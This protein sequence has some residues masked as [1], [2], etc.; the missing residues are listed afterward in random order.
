MPEAVR[1]EKIVAGGVGL[2]RLSDGRVVFVPR[3]APSDLAQVEVIEEHRT[4]TRGR[5]LDVRGPGPER[6]DPPC[7]YYEVCGSCQLQHLSYAAQL[8]AKAG[9]ITDALRRLGGVA[10][11]EPEVIGS[12]RQLEYRNRVT[13]V[14]LREDVV[15]AG[16]HTLHD[17]EAILDVER[18][19]LAEPAINAAWAALRGA[20][21]TDAERLPGGAELRLTLRATAGGKVG[22][23][24]E[25]GEGYGDVE[26]LLESIPDLESIWGL[27]VHGEPEWYAGRRALKDTW[28]GHEL[29]LAGLSF[30]QVN[31]EA[32]GL[33]EE[34]VRAQCGQVA[35]RRI[36]D[37]YCG[38][39][40][41]ALDLA[42]EGA[43]VVGIDADEH[44]IAVAHAA[45]VESAAPARFVA[46]S[47]EGVLANELPADVVLLN[48]PR[49]GLEP[50]VIEALL[51]RPTSRI[52][53]VSCDPATLARDLSGLVQG[54]TLREVKGF[55]LFPQTSHVETVV[56]L[57]RV[58]G[59]GASG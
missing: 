25:G 2:G 58:A 17:P 40:T 53:Y 20:W 22:L 19:P 13:F 59:E 24:I 23:A 27:D 54:F 21:G 37:A 33:L 34:Y 46:E 49:R 28:W 1:I 12:P 44:A 32:A 31:R 8:D 45:A 4:W 47:V 48:P 9:I 29:R 16:Y 56:T 36:I 30:V 52:V 43:R 38:F 26:A 14:L 41:R 15:A 42:W 6:V 50:Q 39:G 7:P 11:E 57:D 35:G 3:T 18:C 10:I 5:L 51:E 55:D